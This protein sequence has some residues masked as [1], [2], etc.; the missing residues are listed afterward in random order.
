VADVAEGRHTSDGIQSLRIGRPVAR[1]WNTAADRYRSAGGACFR[2]LGRTRSELQY[3]GMTGNLY[4][5]GPAGN[6]LAA[7]RT[8]VAT[9]TSAKQRTLRR[10]VRIA[11]LKED[12]QEFCT[13]YHTASLEKVGLAIESRGLLATAGERN[14][15]LQAYSELWRNLQP[16]VLD[17]IQCVT[18]H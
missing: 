10:G 3:P 15:K 16:I 1:R 12:R 4:G 7:A 5:S 13:R 11:G 17:S 8:L 6:G 18:A 9:R 2:S 14:Y